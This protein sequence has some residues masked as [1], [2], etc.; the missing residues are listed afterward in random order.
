MTARVMDI[1]EASGSE[2]EGSQSYSKR[3]MVLLTKTLTKSICP[4]CCHDI[5]HVISPES[6]FGFH[7]YGIIISRRSFPIIMRSKAVSSGTLVDKTAFL[8]F[9]NEGF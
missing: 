5:M 6:D 8:L 4:S 2:N 1:L 7:K 9:H 3:R